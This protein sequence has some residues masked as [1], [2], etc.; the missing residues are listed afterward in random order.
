MAD[1]VLFTGWAAPVRGREERAVE[2]FNETLGMWGRLQQEG[3]IESFDVV[4]L[5]PNGDLGG[6]IAVRGSADQLAA[7]R[8][9]EEFQRVTIAAEL[10]VEGIRQFEG[11]VEDGIAR[12]M[13]LYQEAVAQ[14]APMA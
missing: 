10:A 6:Y 9:T 4:L 11:N 8:Q 3:R 7:I 13:A 1:R 14:L 2:V 5:D 12:G